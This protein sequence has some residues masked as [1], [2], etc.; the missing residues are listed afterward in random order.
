MESRIT[1]R[2]VKATLL[3]CTVLVGNDCRA[4]D[5]VPLA[6][7]GRLPTLENV[8]ISPDGSR[9]AFVKT[10]GEA[11]SLVIAELGKKEMLGGAR[12]GDAKLRDVEWI[13]DDNVLSTVSSTSP[14]PMGF[15]GAT[16]EWYQLVNFNV[17]KM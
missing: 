7:F 14:P 1:E 15:I 9:V 2:T 12:I 17:A 3:L 13:D 5:T 10:S 16:R 4:A 8:V 6:A 11:R